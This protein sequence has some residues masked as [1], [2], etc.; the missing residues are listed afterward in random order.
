MPGVPL[1]GSIPVGGT[2]HAWPCRLINDHVEHARPLHSPYSRTLSRVCSNAC[3]C[4][5]RRPLS[6]QQLARRDWAYIIRVDGDQGHSM[7]TAIH[8][9]DFVGAAAFVDMHNCSNI[10]TIELLVG[11]NRGFAAILLPDTAAK[12]CAAFFDRPG[13]P[14]AR[15]TFRP[16]FTN[17]GF[18]R[19]KC[20]LVLQWSR[21]R[22]PRVRCLSGNYV[23]IIRGRCVRRLCDA[24]A[25]EGEPWKEC[26]TT[27]SGG[28]WVS[29]VPR[30][31]TSGMR[32]N[33]HGD[34]ACSGSH[35]V[36]PSST[37]AK[38]AHR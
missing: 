26:C 19:G 25:R 10:T 13:Y 27:A 30:S 24:H 11:G 2:M 31:I 1:A 14:A 35:A 33:R 9:L 15:C 23:A 20:P 8:K 34:R 36:A 5:L 38:D 6:M 17:D 3:F 18:S 16:A 7:P 21:R 12:L 22:R 28:A 37:T 32:E 4:P 29:C